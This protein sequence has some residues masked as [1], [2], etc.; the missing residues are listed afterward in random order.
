MPRGSIVHKLYSSRNEELNHTYLDFA[1]TT[2]TFLAIAK[3]KREYPI[4]KDVTIDFMIAEYT[5]IF[6]EQVN[7]ELGEDAKYVTFVTR[8]GDILTTVKE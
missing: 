8:I 5:D 4:Y 6:I 1:S 7:Q 3:K 2:S